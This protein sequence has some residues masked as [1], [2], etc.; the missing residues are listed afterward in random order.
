M[1]MRFSP[2]ETQELVIR[3]ICT[4]GGP[5]LTSRRRHGEPHLVSDAFIGEGK[6]DALIEI[7]ST[8]NSG[9]FG[10]SRC[11]DVAA[12]H[13]SMHTTAHK[14]TLF[15]LGVIIAL[16]SSDPSGIN[17]EDILGKSGPER[18]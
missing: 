18:E 15:N 17:R 9:E 11:T 8:T 13:A 10:T 6:K 3:S 16:A 1:L 5:S 4:S 2:T 7:P 12:L 14:T